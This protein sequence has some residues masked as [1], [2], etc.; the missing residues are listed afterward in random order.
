MA[1]ELK[2]IDVFSDRDPGSS[3]FPAQ[4]T[5]IPLHQIK[6]GDGENER[7]GTKVN[8]ESF[9]I[10]ANVRV[11]AEPDGS[12]EVGGDD[13]IPHQMF[14]WGFV[15]DRKPDQSKVDVKPTGSDVFTDYFWGHINKKNSDRFF[16]IS[17]KYEQLGALFD[18]TQTIDPG[19]PPVQSTP[20]VFWQGPRVVFL[21]EYKK[22]DLSITYAFGDDDGKKPITGALWFFLFFD[23]DRP[24]GQ[25][26]MDYDIRV[27]YSNSF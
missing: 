16:V 24:N 13:F 5:W 4:E 6:M 2:W 22:V 14:R 15:Y 3:V 25:A 21:K 10:H 9:N 7:I 8:L 11:T 20:S 23:K 27:E 17:N 18:W 19:P 12:I 26:K 1:P